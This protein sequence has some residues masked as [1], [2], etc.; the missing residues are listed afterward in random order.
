MATTDF[1]RQQYRT[2]VLDHE[3]QKIVDQEQATETRFE[4]QWRG[5]EWRL[6]RSPQV[7]KRVLS[8]PETYLVDVYSGNPHANTHDLRVVYSFDRDR[9]HVHSIRIVDSPSS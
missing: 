8:A 9:V 3:A 4:D 7:G 6:A 2:I 1:P 5:V